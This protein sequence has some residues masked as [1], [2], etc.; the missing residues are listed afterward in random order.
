MKYRRV[1]KSGLK[2]S[3]V[4]YGS[5][6]TFANQVELDNAKKIINRAI[7]LGIN[8]FDS[9]D[10]YERGK[11]EQLLGQILPEKKRSQYVVATKAYWPMSEHETDKGLSRKHVTDSVHA[12]LERLKLDY[13]DI[14]YCHRYD[15]ETPLIESLEA[16][17]DLIKQGKILYWGTSEWTSDQIAEAHKICY[18][19]HWH[20]PIINQPLYN[21]I[22]RNIEKEILPKCVELGMG[23]ANFSP[24]AQGVL[25]GKYSGKNIPSNS[26]G[27]NDKQNMWMKDQINDLALLNNI[28]SLGDIAS[29]YNLT[30]GQLS[31]AWI[32]SNPGISSVITGATSIQQIE[33]NAGASGV[34]LDKIDIEKMNNLFPLL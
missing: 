27:A 22:N 19:K 3:E 28:D 14:F 16:I 25:T 6:L 2:V 24:L 11:A 30:I 5:W 15:T 7:E 29:K 23:T 21:L 13:V 32:L 1:G 31:L 10:A 26:R 12:S 9:A 33:D 17:E 4:A 18:E 20:L 34:L 8:Y